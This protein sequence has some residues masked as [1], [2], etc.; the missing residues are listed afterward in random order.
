MGE[1]IR[2]KVTVELERAEAISVASEEISFKNSDSSAWVAFEWAFL[3]LLNKNIYLRTGVAR[4][5]A[6]Y[7]YD[8]TIKSKE[9]FVFANAVLDY[10]FYLDKI[11]DNNKHATRGECE[12]APQSEDEPN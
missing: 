9:E 10:S 7:Y 2:A 5:L 6:N 12:L 3:E 1:K 4:A 11:C 8:R